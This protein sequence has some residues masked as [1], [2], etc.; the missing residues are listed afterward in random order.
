MTPT[1]K[2]YSKEIQKAID[3][4]WGT[5]NRQALE[6]QQRKT[7]DQ[8]TRGAVTG[9]KQMDGFVNLLKQVAMD[10]GVDE[11][12]IYTAGN[13]L[14]GFFRP[15]KDWDFLII[16]PKKHLIAS[17]ELKS[18]VGSFGNNFNNRTEEALG[19]AVDLWTAFRENVFPKQHSPWVGYVMVLE[20]SSESM[21]PV[22]VIEPHF[23]ALQEF[24]NTSYA[25]RYRLLCK[26]LMLERH[27]TATALILTSKK[28]DYRSLSEE[29]SIQKM[30]AS[31]AGYLSG[32]IQEF[33]E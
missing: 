28:R 5:R 13:P 4:F 19:S 7:E 9:G 25:E 8:G 6:Q 10:M 21:K 12:Y 2:D 1:I 27:Y 20:E 11:K 33:E 32:K 3:Y 17:V 16:S 14:P 22:K 31:F 23:K 29:V 24:K 18:Q 26:K 30:I 15:S